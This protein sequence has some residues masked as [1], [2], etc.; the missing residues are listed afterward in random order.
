MTHLPSLSFSLPYPSP[1]ITIG[2]PVWAIQ[3]QEDGRYVSQL[4]KSINITFPHPVEVSDYHVT[5]T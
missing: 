4:N 5:I 1:N 3:L 2:A